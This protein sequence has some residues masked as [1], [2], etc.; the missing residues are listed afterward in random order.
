MN[1]AS[2]GIRFVWVFGLLLL[3]GTTLGA[4]WVWHQPNGPVVGPDSTEPVII[5]VRGAGFVDVPNRVSML[6]PV[7]PGRVSY[8]CVKEGD[9]VNEGE[10]LLSLDDSMARLQVRQA[11]A[12]LDAAKAKLH[13]AER[14]LV[15][16]QKDDIKLEEMKLAIANEKV[17]AA[18]NVL[19]IQEKLQGGPIKTGSEE[20]VAAA[21]SDEVMAQDAVKVQE[22]VISRIKALDFSDDLKQL[23]AD[24]QAKEAQLD[25][26]HHALFECDVYAPADGVVLQLFANVGDALPPQPRQPAITFASGPLVLRVEILQEWAEKLEKGQIAYIAD[27]TR[28]GTVW[29]GKLTQISKQFTHRRSTI[30]EPFQFNDVRMLECI[31][32]FDPNSRPVRMGQRMRVTIAQGGL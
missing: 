15:R 23:R 3:L 29:K 2:R 25:L 7:Q 1:I 12:A 17:A 16:N 4:G 22:L 27:D 18:A 6:H 9:S 30:Q 8:L 24:V 14:D 28:A 10:M 19:R 26:A 32:E 5:G 13:K 31:V 21:K 20:A 11:Q